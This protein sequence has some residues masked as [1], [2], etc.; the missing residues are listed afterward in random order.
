MKKLFVILVCLTAIFVANTGVR[1]QEVTIVLNPGW[2]W[3]SF[4]TTDTLDI[5]EAF[6][7]FTPMVG[8]QVKSKWVSSSYLSN[9]HWRGNVTEFYPGH[10]YM[11]KS[12]RSVPVFVTF[13]AQQQPASQ[14]VVVTTSEPTDITAIAATCGGEVVSNDGTYIIVKG[15]CW[16]THENP[17]TNDDFYE[18]AESGVGS[19]SIFM[20]DLN[21]STTYYVR[22]Y[23]VTANGTVYGVQ[24]TFTTRDGIPTLTTMEVSNITGA[25]ATCGGNITDNGGLNV[26]A[27]GVC[28]STSPNPTI[29]DSHTTNGSGSGSFS[30]NITGLN[31]STTY[32]VR[33]YATTAAGTGYGEQKT[34]TTRDGIP[35]LTTTDITNIAKTSAIGGG[36]ITDDGGLNITARGVCWST[37]PNP[38]VGGN[39]FY[40]GYGTGSFTNSITGLDYSTTYYVRAFAITDVGTTYGNEVSFTTLE[41]TWS[42]G[43]SP[44]TFSVSEHSQVHFSQGNLQYR[45]S[46]NTWKFAEYQWDYV[47]YANEGISSTNNGWID[48]FG[49]GTSGYNHG[50]NCYQPWSTSQTDGD[51]YAY[52]S[53]T[54]NLYDQTGKAD[55]GYNAISNGGNSINT[56]RTLTNFEWYYVLFSRNTSSGIR[57]AVAKV[58]GV[59]GLILLPDDWSTA[60]YSLSNANDEYASFNNNIVSATQWTTLEN[61]GAVFLPAA[62]CFTPW[63]D[64]ID[65]GGDGYYWSASHEDEGFDYVY[66]M[67]FGPNTEGGV[68]CDIG[69][70][71]GWHLSRCNR[72]SVRLVCS[73]MPVITTSVSSIT[74]TTA[75]FEGRIVVSGFNSVTECGICWS[76]EPTPTINDN[77]LIANGVT[78]G[79]FSLELTDLI[80]NTKYYV[81]AYAI[82]SIGTGYSSEMS[83]TCRNTP[84]GSING[85]FSVSSTSQVYFS[86]GNLQYQASTNTWKFAE[87]QWDYVGRG[88]GIEWGEKDWYDDW[89]YGNADGTVLGSSNYFISSAYPGWIDL[90]G[91]GTSGYN[92]GANCYQPWS[93]SQTSSNYYAYGNYN[94]NLNDQNGQADWGYNAISNGGNTNN[95]WR[96]LTQSEWNYLFN[97]RVTTS[98]IRYAKAELYPIIVPCD[99]DIQIPCSING[100]ILLPDD[101]SPTTYSLNSTNTYNASFSSNTITASQWSILENAGAVFLPASGNRN[102][103]E[104][105]NVNTKGFYW[106]ASSNGSNNARNVLINDSS[107]T[108]NDSSGRRNGLSVR[109]VRNAE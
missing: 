103:T 25:T 40:N 35:T 12:N 10:G 45:A 66:A 63:E 78:T 42:N 87:N 36:N 89:N 88:L 15:I 96:T 38:T 79:E 47:G 86:Q 84:T 108:S 21:I 11:Y 67:R 62:G 31:V 16:A 75:T 76:T 46:T 14:V 83:F 68:I 99:D 52:G 28:W 26:T 56:W 8:D 64:F 60:T 94:Y 1:A 106:T 70:Y 9:G 43:I 97:T 18:E 19:F 98:G 72:L 95:T 5:S 13:N 92:H 29:A 48:L 20:T 2:N 39:H 41:Q 44:A 32:Y 82:N 77:K 23:A 61:V 37:S 34:L 107:L 101:W 24:K 7:S 100:V 91:W 69:P 104:V 50:A 51:Y 93:T 49:W 85:L 58:N 55:W 73:E 90:F 71:G 17:T 80:P 4:P 102:G 109:L 59:N 74:E 105:S 53:A 57:F 22:A 6:G 65:V 3:I 81:R 27:R 30:S 33:A 54:Y